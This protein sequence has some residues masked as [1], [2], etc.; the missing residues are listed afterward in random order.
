MWSVSLV[1]RAD[2]MPLSPYKRRILVSQC[3]RYIPIFP[4]L[5]LL[6]LLMEVDRHQ[7]NRNNGTRS[8]SS[9]YSERLSSPWA[10]YSRDAESSPLHGS[11]QLSSSLSTVDTQEARNGVIDLANRAAMYARRGGSDQ[12]EYP[13]PADDG[14]DVELERPSKRR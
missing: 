14:T 2:T 9:R 1:M 7:S 12:G 5:D 3:A 6:I 11:S 10:G 4:P 13:D 8:Q